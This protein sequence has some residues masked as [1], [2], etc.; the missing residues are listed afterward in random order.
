MEL[1]DETKK[2]W[3]RFEEQWMISGNYSW[4]RNTFACFVLFIIFPLTVDQTVRLLWAYS[5]IFQCQSHSLQK[6][7]PTSHIPFQN[8]RILEW[9]RLE[10]TVKYH[11]ALTY[12]TWTGTFFTRT[13]FQ[14]PVQPETLAL[15][16]MGHTQLLWEICF[17]V[18]L[19]LL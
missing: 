2:G 5:M 1:R 14:S 18:S 12:P 3:W 11:L 13:S 8:Y 17:G 9:F 19:P 10:G 15:S 16:T 4:E 7:P 6:T